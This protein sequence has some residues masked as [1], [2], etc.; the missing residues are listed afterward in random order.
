MKFAI[1]ESISTPGGHEVDFDRLLTEEL[2]ALGHQVVFYVPE[3]FQF[4]IDYKVPVRRLPGRG[5][6]YT[7]VR[8][9]QKILLSAKRE[10]NRQRWYRAIY[11]L[12]LQKD[13]DAVIVPTSTYR[14]LRGLRLSKLKQSPVPVIFVVHGV[15]PREAPKFFA[16]AERLRPY[17]HI[18]MA[19]LTFGDRLFDRECPNVTCLTPPTYLPR[20][21]A[22]NH[23]LP[24]AGAGDSRPLV[25][26]FFGQ[27]RRE[28][29]LD[30]FL[31]AF[32]QGTYQRPVKLLVQ[33][34]TMNP[35]DAADFERIIQTYSGRADVEFLH[36]GLIGREWQ[37]AIAA[38]DALLMPYSAPRY[39]YHWGGMLFTAIGYKKPVI[40]SDEIN[41][42]VLERYQ[43]GL[44]YDSSRMGALQATVEQFINTYGDRADVYARELERAYRDYH[45]RAFANRLADLARQ[46]S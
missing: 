33:G 5:V 15:N 28:K 36:K 29:K 17:P 14:Y 3:D 38:V 12:A 44:A 35:D 1:F 20:D 41:P 37:E 19:V 13:V 23:V 30:V 26:G 27:Y 21:L 6:S 2:V 9:L 4:K 32:L 24:A 11:H 16:A 43:I 31:E 45:P 46:L 40:L 8:G 7:G 34:S 22:P 10:I 42:E 39:R 18:R 25:L